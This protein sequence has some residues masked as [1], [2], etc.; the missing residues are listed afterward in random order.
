M[1]VYVYIYLYSNNITIFLGRLT[2]LALLLHDTTAQRQWDQDDHKQPHHDSANGTTPERS[3]IGFLTKKDPCSGSA[4]NMENVGS[5]QPVIMQ[6]WQKSMIAAAAAWLDSTESLPGHLIEARPGSC[7]ASP[8]E[9]QAV[10]E[11]Q[12]IK[13][14]HGHLVLGCPTNGSLGEWLDGFGSSMVYHIWQSDLC[15]GLRQA[16]GARPQTRRLSLVSSNS[17]KTWIRRLANRFNFYLSLSPGTLW[18]QD[19]NFL[20]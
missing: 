16:P 11:Q 7:L 8:R 3:R 20:L 1:C 6:L 15:Y 14:C 17:L 5:L 18:F 10:K 19:F 13:C 9:N 4:E 2:C 12:S